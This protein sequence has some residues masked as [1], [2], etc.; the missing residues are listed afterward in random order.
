MSKVRAASS[1]QSG[2]TS[3]GFWAGMAVG[4]LGL[5]F[6][7]ARLGEFYSILAYIFVCLAL[8]LIFWLVPSLII[9]AVAVAL[10]GVFIGPLFPTGMVLLTKMMPRHLH[11]G[12][13][14]FAAAF[15][16]GGGAIFPFI[17]GAIAQR[18][19]VESLQPVILAI[20]IL[21]ASLWMC[22]PKSGKKTHG[23][24][25]EIDGAR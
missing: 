11:V 21:I 6:V 15:G 13:V 16:G 10:L 8:E 1:F 19:G 22:L 12:A 3:A 25:N 4:R 9:S 17:V 2:A 20:L 7:T 5:S 14:G 23:E 24:E 18:K